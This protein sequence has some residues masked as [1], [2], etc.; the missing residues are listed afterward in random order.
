MKNRERLSVKTKRI[1][2]D[3]ERVY[4]LLDAGMSIDQVAKQFGVSRDTIYRRHREYQ[5]NNM[6]VQEGL[7]K[8]PNE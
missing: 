3:I 5:K 8:L 2:I 4:K 7:P 6:H 1:D